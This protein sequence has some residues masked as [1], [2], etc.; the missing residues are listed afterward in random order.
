MDDAKPADPPLTPRKAGATPSLPWP[1]I[2]L[3]VNAVLFTALV[4]AGVI[5]IFQ[6]GNGS[7][8]ATALRLTQSLFAFAICTCITVAAALIVLSPFA[9]ASLH[10]VRTRPQATER[11]VSLHGRVA[12]LVASSPLRCARSDFFH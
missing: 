5:H 3:M 4:T 11:R 8:R 2:S 7:H 6:G 10:C 12:Q 9:R 1:F